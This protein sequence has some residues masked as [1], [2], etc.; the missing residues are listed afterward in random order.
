MS[1]K[2]A[3][4][5]G[6][7]VVDFVPDPTQSLVPSSAALITIRTVNTVAVKILALSDITYYFNSDS[8]KTFLVKAGIETI[9]M[10]ANPGILSLNIVNTSTTAVYMQ[11]M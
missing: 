4:I 3:A 7:T 9:I 10:V 8:T 2:L 1:K 5:N 11:G 6:I